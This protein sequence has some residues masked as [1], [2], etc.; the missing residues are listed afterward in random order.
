MRADFERV[1]VLAVSRHFGRRRV[2]TNVSFDLAAG[3]I[4]GLVGPNGAG[5]STVLSILSTLLS[6]SSGEVRYGQKTAAQAGQDIRARVGLLA[7]ELG[8]YS[9]LTARENLT[10]FAHL[11]G[12]DRRAGAIAD[13]ALERAG[14]IGRADDPVSSLSRG[15]R[16]RLAL[17]RALLHEP[18][19][20]LLDEPLTGL[21]EASGRALLQRLAAMRAA[22]CI[23]VVASHDF[24][25]IEALL[26]R[27]VLLKD[28]RVLTLPSGRG[29]LRERYRDAVGSS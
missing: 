21:D 28:G 2:L 13:G 8:L 9:D 1:T 25:V 3:E 10:F 11:Y 15:M 6:P 14:L 29:T 19:L 22:G 5:K 16:Q 26:D 27:V 12:A 4:V 24:D 17:E 20:V 7:H 18:R 23:V